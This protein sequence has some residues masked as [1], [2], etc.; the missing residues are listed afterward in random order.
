[1]GLL[2]LVNIYWARLSLF[3]GPVLLCVRVN[4]QCTV[5]LLGYV[6]S[7]SD[8]TNAYIAAASACS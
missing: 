3:I 5:S 4:K 7:F 2:A 8:Y 1:M 6:G